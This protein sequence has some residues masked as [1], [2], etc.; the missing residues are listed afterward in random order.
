[1]RQSFI[2]DFSI[3]PE[4]VVT[5]PAGPNMERFPTEAALHIGKDTAPTVLF[6]GRQFERKGGPMLLHAFRRVRE[7]LPDARLLIAGCT[8]D[9][10]DIP[11]VTVLGA[12]SSGSTGPGSLTAAY[13]MAHLFCMPS[14][15]E[16]FGVVF[17]EAMMHGVP[18]IAADAWAMPELVQ[19]DRTGWLVREGDH[20]ELAR[21]LVNALGDLPRLRRMG[22]AARAH[23]S[24][25]FSWSRTAKIMADVLAG[26]VE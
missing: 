9:V 16:P 23:A 25:T 6:V 22:D 1:L 17:V 11:G 19:D 18:C 8:P 24:V 4:R 7:I 13:Q 2:H 14:H 5:A 21:T 26:G 15:Y 20:E 12:L 10:G 3:P